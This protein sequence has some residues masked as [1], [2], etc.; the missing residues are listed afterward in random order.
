MCAHGL[1]HMAV[2]RGRRGRRISFF[3]LEGRWE[4][5][6]VSQNASH[7]ARNRNEKTQFCV[8]YVSCHRLIRQTL[9]PPTAPT[10]RRRLFAR[11]RERPDAPARHRLG[12]PRQ[13]PSPAPAHVFPA[14]RPARG[15]P[16]RNPGAGRT[17]RQAP[18]AKFRT[19]GGRGGQ[20]QSP[21]G[22]KHPAASPPPRRIRRRKRH[23]I[24]PP[25]ASSADG[26]TPHQHPPKP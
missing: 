24:S 21:E 17:R 23:W 5:C 12:H 25:A 8:L 7:G 3:L 10:P 18:P 22:K 2:S 1:L 16:P 6:S 26:Q 15:S 9:Q 19:P 20:R 4:T 14:G 13:A 11:P